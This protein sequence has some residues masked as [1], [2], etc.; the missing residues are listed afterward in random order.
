M[1]KDN[2]LFFDYKLKK[3]QLTTRNAIKI[4]DLNGYP[5]EVINEAKKIAEL[6][7]IEKKR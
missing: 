5:K 4:L 6:V 1:V 2:E 7:E 3:G